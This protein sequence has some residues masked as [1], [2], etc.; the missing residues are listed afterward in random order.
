VPAIVLDGT[1]LRSYNPPYLERGRI[2]APLDPFV[3]SIA[4]GV[5]YSAGVLIVRRADRFAQIP[6]KQ[7]YPSHFQSTYVPI[8]PILRSLGIWF[9]YDPISHVLLVRT[10]PAVLATPTP[11][12]PAV[13]Q[14]APRIV[15]TP[16]PVQTARP[17]V[18][19]TPAP[20]RTPLPF[21]SP[22]PKCL[23]GCDRRPTHRG[24]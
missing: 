8:A 16:T 22:A 24:A 12:N 14:A 21:S 20:R 13:P 3:T 7:P 6:M 17:I 5:E 18:T 4:A 23:R 11:F 2:M 1:A 9:S 19:G 15:F 10:P